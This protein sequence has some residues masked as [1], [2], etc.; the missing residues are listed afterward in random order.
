MTNAAPATARDPRC[1]RCQSVGEPV[2]GPSGT[3]EN[4][5]IGDIQARC[6]KVMSRSVIGVN[7]CAVM[8]SVDMSCVQV[9]KNDA[10]ARMSDWEP[11]PYWIANLAGLLSAMSK[12]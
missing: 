9:F 8:L 4:C 11:G 7:R 2:Y 6:A 10:A 12:G 5:I 1:C 3:A